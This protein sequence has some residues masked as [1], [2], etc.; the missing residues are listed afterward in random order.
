[1]PQTFSQIDRAVAALPVQ[2]RGPGGAVAVIRNGETIVRH[3][4]GYA[5]LDRR[6]PMSPQSLMPICSVTKQFTCG[7]MLDLFPDPSVL[8]GD[9]TAWLPL[10]EGPRPTALQLAHNQSGLRDYWALTVLH[11][12]MAE[13]VFT[14]KDARELIGRTRS[15]HFAP[16]HS[17]SY[18]NGNFHM[19]GE[20][21]AGR[22]G[23]DLGDLLSERILVPAG[24]ESARLAPDTAQR[25]G[26]VMGYEGN[27]TTGFFPAIN[28]IWWAGDAGMVAS[29]DDLIAWEKFI[30]RTRDEAGGL[31]ARLSQ[32][33]T[34][35]DGN[36]AYYGFGLA[37][38][39]HHGVHTI[40]HGGALRGWRCHRVH[41]PSERLSVVVMFNHEA[42]A[43]AAAF[44]VLDAARGS[45]SVPGEPHLPDQAFKGHFLCRETGL[46]VT[47]TP[48]PGSSL[49]LR[50]G[51]GAEILN[52]LDEKTAG[53]DHTLLL[54]GGE[55]LRMER[56]QE[57]FSSLL[58]PLETLPDESL[59]SPDD[60]AGRYIAP[61][62]QSELEITVSG[63]Q[64]FAAFSGFLG[65]GAVQP[66]FPV[67]PDVWLMPVRRSMDAPAPGDFTLL[68]RR[69]AAGRVSGI[70]AGC[71]LARHNVFERV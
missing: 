18:S 38:A 64:P 24:M 37:H 28:R 42:N 8:D 39:E 27:A 51:T 65:K 9:L 12:A 23:R 15:T 50:Y 69:N 56:P 33:Q 31:Y 66:L 32:P 20:I 4:W 26:D 68:V 63:G 55:G 52:L 7:L 22:A 35:A 46:S 49:H 57:N 60:I 34:F 43:R 5:D 11:G 40:G 3:A 47:L 1:M 19:L 70:E 45:A 44:A 41:V 13:G 16:G 58:Q 14:A 2:W 21:L 6:I 48:L 25:P 10:M 61:E 36:P 62:L 30:D 59:V 67:S 54:T 53:G 71:W 29:L 17:Y